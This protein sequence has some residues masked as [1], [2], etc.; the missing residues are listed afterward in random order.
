MDICCICNEP[1]SDRQSVVIREKGA[2]HINE[3][4]K[5][6]NDVIAV[7]SGDVL[8]QDCRREYTNQKA[9]KIKCRE[10]RE[11]LTPNRILRS[12][13][14]FNYRDNCLF[15]SQ[16]ASLD[17]K[18]RGTDSFLV[19]TSDFQKNIIKLCKERND[20]WATQILA[21]IHYAQDLHAADA[22]YH[23]QCSVNFRTG[24]NVPS[25]TPNQKKKGTGRPQREESQAAF[26]QT[27][28][29]LI[30]N[31]DEQL[32]VN[33]MVTKMSE[34]CGE[35]LSYSQVHM[36]SK[37]QNHFGEDVIITEI[38]GRP[39]VI[40]LRKTAKNILQDFHQSQSQNDPEVEKLNILKAAAN[41][42][43]SDIKHISSS[44]SEYP[45]VADIE[46]TESNLNYIP[47]SLKTFL[48]TLFS[49][50]NVDVKVSSIGQSVV[51]AA[52]PRSLIAPLQIGLAVQ[53]HHA[54]GSRFLIDTLN[55]LGFSSSYSEVQRYEL[56]AAKM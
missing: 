38:N 33:D 8:H 24:K 35:N 46:S 14:Q 31:E 22:I 18:R 7:A 45:C 17:D 53:M 29:Y 49:E 25:S 10:P 28:E 51:Q 55:S 44:K 54:F 26:C 9:I 3:C 20:D 15:C 16:P 2:K 39:N 21:R 36:K 19:R 12:K 42:I 5:L 1:I 32:T 40:T 47:E 52:R 23:Q 37:I 4:S 41:L 50:S 27:L 6:R 11:P 43:K 48:R 13:E 34:L 56:N 30:K